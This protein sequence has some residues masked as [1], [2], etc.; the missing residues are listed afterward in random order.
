MEVGRGRLKC[1][2]KVQTEL[3]IYQVQ[4][5]TGWVNSWNPGRYFFF[6]F[7]F[8]FAMELPTWAW[9]LGLICRVRHTTW[10]QRR[11]LCTWKLGCQCQN[12][13]GN[14]NKVLAIVQAID[15]R[16]LALLQLRASW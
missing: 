12:E 7:F 15:L 3:K 6:F 11:N 10:L 14:Q 5:K 1:H 16:L 4:A 2:Y 9:E 8:F 13:P